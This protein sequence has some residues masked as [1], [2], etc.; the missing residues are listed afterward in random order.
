MAEIDRIVE[1]AWEDRTPF[2]SIKKTFG[3]TE[4]EVI[5]LMR[6]QMKKSSF[7]MWRDRMKGRKTKHLQKR[8]DSV[9]RFMCAR[10][11]RMHRR[12]K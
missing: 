10:Q 9:N 2:E 5:K 4:G 1:M 8:D 6:K 11:P 3:L 12:S 7:V